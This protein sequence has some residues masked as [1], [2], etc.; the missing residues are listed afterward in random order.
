MSVGEIKEQVA[1]LSREE[2][3]DLSAFI[4]HLTRQNDLEWQADIDRT[5]AEMDAGKKFTKEDILRMHNELL[6]QDR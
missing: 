5:M 3:L 2:L 6:A 1:V 4:A